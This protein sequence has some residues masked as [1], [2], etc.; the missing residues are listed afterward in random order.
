MNLQI[1]YRPV[2]EL[3]PYANNA[4]KHDEKNVAEIAAAISKYGFL[5]PVAVDKHGVLVWGHGRVLAAKQLN[6]SKIPVI[7]LPSDLTDDELKALR[8]Q[9][10]K[11]AEKSGWDVDKL[12]AELGALD[13]SGFDISSI[14]F[15]TS[16]LD[17]LLGEIGELEPPSF[18][19]ANPPVAATPQPAAPPPNLTAYSPPEAD[20]LET[21]DSPQAYDP[22]P[23]ARQPNASDDEY[24]QFALTMLHEHKRE[25]LDVLHNVRTAHELE[26][27]E[28]ALM[29]VV[30]AYKV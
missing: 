25:L 24:S 27:L 23:Q 8:L 3:V 6:I 10:N 21:D 30:R 19:P 28:D 20:E 22:P 13:V 14:G 26:K 7:A 29:L 2:S 1:K 4:R 15:S 16:E 17:T 5:D 12:A 11:L 18:A 9:H